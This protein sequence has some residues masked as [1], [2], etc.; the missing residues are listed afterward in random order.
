MGLWKEQIR[1]S[2][3]K[4]AFGYSSSHYDLQI[5]SLEIL[6]VPVAHSESIASLRYIALSDTFSPPKGTSKHSQ[7]VPN[8]FHAH[9]SYFPNSAQQAH[10]V[11]YK[12]DV[13]HRQISFKIDDIT[14]LRDSEERLCKPRGPILYPHPSTQNSLS[15]P[16]HPPQR[17][18]TVSKAYIIDQ[19]HQ[20]IH[21]KRVD[22]HTHTHTHTYILRFTT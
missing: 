3:S 1:W 9:T 14:A 2:R 12:H 21:P 16:G 22:I 8:C 6:I 7:Y 13:T 18:L 20:N 15:A 11:S 10:K 17:P 5:D 19:S 4:D